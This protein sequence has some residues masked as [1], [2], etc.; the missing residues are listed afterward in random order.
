MVIK[1]RSKLILV[2]E[3]EIYKLLPWRQGGG[4]T[5]SEPS[6]EMGAKCCM[7]PCK[8]VAIHQLYDKRRMMVFLVIIIIIIPTFHN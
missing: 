6:I 3:S 4:N 2:T 1:K 5:Y 7:S 8:G